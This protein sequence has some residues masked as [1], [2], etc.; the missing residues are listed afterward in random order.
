MELKLVG[1]PTV[2]RNVQEGGPR[3]VPAGKWRSQGGYDMTWGQWDRENQKKLRVHVEVPDETL[4]DNLANRKDRPYEDW[5][6]LVLEALASLGVTDVRLNWSQ[7][8]GCSCPCSPGFIVTGKDGSYPLKGQTVWVTIASSEY[9]EVEAERVRKI[10]AR[11]R[12]DLRAL[13][14]QDERMKELVEV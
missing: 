11:D 6:P 7:R 14:K 9:D 4:L 10:K 1:D 13:Q 8:A 5:R 2:R 3:Y 12:E